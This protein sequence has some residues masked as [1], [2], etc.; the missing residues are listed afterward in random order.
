MHQPDHPSTVLFIVLFLVASPPLLHARPS[1]RVTEPPEEVVT[2][3]DLDPFYDQ[4]IDVQDVPIVAS[5]R[6]SAYA[7]LEAA[8]LIRRMVQ[9]RP[10][11]LNGLVKHRIRFVVLAH[12]EMTTDIPE[13]SDLP[14]PD[15]WDR[16]ARGLGA[17]RARPAVSCGEENLLE[18]PGDPYASENILIHE[19]AHSLFTFGVLEIDRSYEK[20]LRETYEYAMDNGLWKGTYAAKNPQEYWAEGVQSWFNTNREN[21]GQH[22]HVDTRSELKTYDPKLARLLQD[23]FRNNKWRYTPPRNRST[24]SHLKGYNPDRAP[25]FRWPDDLR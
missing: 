20:R 18:Y 9:K 15:H 11:L 4:Y 10:E 13:Y 25:T 5:E 3:F 17:T 12:D 16:R 2:S 8:Y 23:V 22:N 1:Y 14:N 7:L 21:D 19:F 24:S 6:V